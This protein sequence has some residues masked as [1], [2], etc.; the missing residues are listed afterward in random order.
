MLKLK[1]STVQQM[2]KIDR[3]PALAV[4][5]AKTFIQNMDRED[6]KSAIRL[7]NALDLFTRYDPEMN[8]QTLQ[9]IVS[10]VAP[11]ATEAHLQYTPTMG[12]LIGD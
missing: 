10:G 9:L 5:V 7:V 2:E 8:V 1:D 3:E 11:A 4:S 6:Q 12:E